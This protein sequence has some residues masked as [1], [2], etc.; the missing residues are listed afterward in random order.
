MY[1]SFAHVVF[2]MSIEYKDTVGNTEFLLTRNLWHGDTDL[3][4]ISIQM[5]C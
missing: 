3:G 4:A 2:E 1:L 5:V